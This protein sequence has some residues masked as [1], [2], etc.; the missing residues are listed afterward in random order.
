MNYVWID[1][2]GILT[3]WKVSYYYEKNNVYI[4]CSTD[5]QGGF[6]FKK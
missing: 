5:L 3:V 2:Q 4:I 6:Y 1:L